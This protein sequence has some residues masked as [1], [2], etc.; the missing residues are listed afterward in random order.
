MLLKCY[1]LHIDIILPRH[2]IFCIFVSMSTSRSIN[3][4]I[5]FSLSFS[6]SLQLHI[7]SLKQPHVFIWTFFVKSLASGCCLAFA[8]FF[9]NF[10]LVLL[11]KM[12]LIKIQVLYYFAMNNFHEGQW[13]IFPFLPRLYICNK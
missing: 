13:I 4:M 1:L 3:C 10:N 2:A 8:F 9:A 5:Y 7:I 6:V 11:I 12:F